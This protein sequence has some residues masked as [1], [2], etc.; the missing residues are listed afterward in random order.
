MSQMSDPGATDRFDRPLRTLRVSVT[1][2]CNLRCS[3][4]MP[5]EIYGPDFK[6]LPRSEVLT[7]E[8][9][10]LL[11]GAFAKAG[12]RRV[13]IT[14]G[15]PLLRRDLP[16][17]V[18]LLTCIE[19]SLELSLTTNGVRLEHFAGELLEAGLHRI[20]VSLDGLD[21][22]VVSALAGRAVD[23][24]LIWNNI[25]LAQEMGFRV[26]VNAVLRPGINES[27]AVPLAA[28]CR[29]AGIELRYIEYMDVGRTNGWQRND[30]VS[31]ARVLAMLSREWDLVPA[32]DQSV[33]ETAR[34]Y[35]YTD[36]GVQVGFINS[37]TEPFCGGCDRARLS[38]SGVLYTCLFAETGINLKEWI[39][40][41]SLEEAAMVERL[42][43]H[44]GGRTDRYSELRGG[45][46]L[47]T[48]PQRPEM[49]SLGG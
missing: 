22:E 41:E 31:G 2:R 43:R 33:H 45:A 42:R 7:Y 28:R 14:G 8:E 3:Y 4:C 1:D 38:A 23:P 26:K 17:L 16:R 15:E 12:V 40:G 34:R 29:E 20:N 32:S 13:R 44:W 19:P 49:W 35:V 11:V 48:A 21:K 27:Q 37:I 24:E 18:Q 36:T 39:R 25:L 9:I 46:V 6:F 10:T 5:A 30:V 47:S